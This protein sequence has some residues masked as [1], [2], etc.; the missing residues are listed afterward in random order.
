MA[1]KVSDASCGGVTHWA[2]VPE[3]DD[4][5]TVAW[6]QN[7]ANGELGLGVDEPKSA[8]KPTKNVPLTGVQV[9][10]VAAGQNTTVLIAQPNEKMSDLP[11]HPDVDA[12]EICVV[13][14]REREDSEPLICDKCDF[15][16]HTG[17]LNPPL[18]AVPEGEWFCPRCD[19]RGGGA[20]RGREE[21][22]S[23]KGQSSSRLPFIRQ[24]TFFKKNSL[25][26]VKRKK[27]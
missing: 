11:R 22:L 23:A 14:N 27:P 9:F 7:A 12:P 13:C 18:D 20:K 1:C 17:C 4:V 5:M 21:D 2:L 8:T 15:P 26:G 25:G 19:G 6:G 10:D 3:D 16:Y 24:L